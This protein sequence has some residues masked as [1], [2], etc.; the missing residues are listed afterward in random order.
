VKG[1]KGRILRFS[2]PFSRKQPKKGG[3]NFINEGNLGLNSQIFFRK[4][5]FRRR[6]GNI[7]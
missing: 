1:P 6:A 4:M 2:A 5:S 3:K 7:F